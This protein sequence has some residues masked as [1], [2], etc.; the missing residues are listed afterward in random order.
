MSIYKKKYDPDLQTDRAKNVKGDV[1]FI[2]FAESGRKGYFCLGCGKPMQANIQRKN[3]SYKSYFSH[4]PVDIS[5][6]EKKCTYSNREQRERIATDI[7]HRLKRIKVPGVYKYPPKGISGNPVEL[8]RA[9]FIEAH[10]VRSQVTFYENEEGVIFSGKNPEVLDRYHLLIPDVIFYNEKDEPI[11]FIELVDTHK[12]SDE[13]KIKLRRIGINTVSIIV[14]RGSDQEIE[15]NFKSIERVKWEYN[16][17]EANT[18]Y[19]SVSHRAPKGLLDIDEDQRRIFGESIACRRS[20]IRNA[21]RGIRACLDGESYRNAE[22]GFEREIFRVKKATEG[23]RERLG[24]LEREYE[25][26]IF[27]GFNSEYQELQQRQKELRRKKEEFQDYYTNLEERYFRK[28]EEIKLDQAKI[29]EIQRAELE[30][31][32]TEEEIR[33]RFESNGKELR[34]ELER[35]SENFRRIIDEENESIRKAKESIREI[36]T[37]GEAQSRRYIQLNRDEHDGFRDRKSRME[38]DIKER[39]RIEGESLSR[40]ISEEER[41]IEELRNKERTLSEDFRELEERERESFRE[42]KAGIIEKE[43]RF[44][45]SIHEELIGELRRSS[46]GL[47]K[48]IGFILEAQ[49]VGCNYKDAQRQEAHYKRA[50]ELFNKGAWKRE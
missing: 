2:D 41:S 33:A 31:G 16:E 49:T 29:N 15:D 35:I 20:G 45:E 27:S 36:S 38:Q 21:I 30:N 5:K 17:E 14:P 39:F 18:T 8:S 40:Y 12:V 7:L 10:K 42:K 19:L 47:P 37:R 6:G 25:E 13:K 4:I 22:Q 48:R 50:R 44:Q 1:I 3:P 23:A 46:S 34:D 26:E 24:N 11:L 28:A 9:K 43:K 32:G